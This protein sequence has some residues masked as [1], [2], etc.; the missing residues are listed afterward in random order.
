MNSVS[1]DNK[2]KQKH[3]EDAK[4]DL[5]QAFCS[6][7]QLDDAQKRQLIAELVGAE[8]AFAIYSVM[9]QFFG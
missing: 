8:T 3:F 1:E 5:V 4:K 7:S 9:Q 2:T 6:F